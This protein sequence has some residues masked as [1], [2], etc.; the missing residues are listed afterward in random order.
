[1]FDQH[2]T[3]GTVTRNIAT[4]CEL[5]LTKIDHPDKLFIRK[6]YIKMG[7]KLVK[8]LKRKV[9]HKGRMQVMIN[10]TPQIGKST[11]LSYLL[12]IIPRYTHLKRIFVF[13]ERKTKR[14][15]SHPEA[16]QVVLSVL[17]FNPNCENGKTGDPGIPYG[18]CHHLPGYREDSEKVLAVNTKNHITFLDG[19]SSIPV[20]IDHYGHVVVFTSQGFTESCNANTMWNGEKWYMPPWTEDELEAYH[21][22]ATEVF[23]EDVTPSTLYEF[24][25]GS[26]GYSAKRDFSQMLSYLY[27]EKVQR[28]VQLFRNYSSMHVALNL[29]ERNFTAAFYKIIPDKDTF[30]EKGR[31]WLTPKLHD[32]VLYAVKSE[33]AAK[34]EETQ[35]LESGVKRGVWF[36]DTFARK[37]MIP[38]NKIKM[39][40]YKNYRLVDKWFNENPE[41]VEFSLSETP[42]MISHTGNYFPLRLGN[43]NRLT[44]NAESVDYYIA[45]EINTSAGSEIQ[46]RIY[47]LQTTIRKRHE[48]NFGKIAE[49]LIKM[50]DTIRTNKEKRQTI[51][52]KRSSN[53]EEDKK[54][55]EDILETNKYLEKDDGHDMTISLLEKS[56]EIWLVYLNEA[57]MTKFS[58]PFNKPKETDSKVPKTIL[59]SKL[60][61]VYAHVNL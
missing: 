10:G 13:S 56:V 17:D 21:K 53:K 27:D 7:K 16:K 6:C 40:V 5:K 14:D 36:E 50:N 9:Q 2:V 28:H 25:G 61:T 34:S 8:V 42:R 4:E 33:I 37:W 15:P 32:T 24:F 31:E 45:S 11:F 59:L 41:S 46:Y 43:L 35:S 12:G 38:N 39:Y 51:A 55:I 26:I 22:Q 19:F 54:V 57:M 49:Y 3:E 20:T 44:A 1:M 52:E 60:K 23:P 48:A 30:E 58:G 18:V 47:L 29:N